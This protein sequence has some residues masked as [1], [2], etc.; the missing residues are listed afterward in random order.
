MRRRVIELRE[1]RVIRDQQSG[2][3]RPDESTSE[4]AVRLRGELGIGVEGHP[5]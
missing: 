3:Y 2:L 4:F 1:G 5:N